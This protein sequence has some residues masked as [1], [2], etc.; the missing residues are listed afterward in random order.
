MNEI[1]EQ[2]AWIVEGVYSSWLAE[3]FKKA[4]IILVIRNSIFLQSYRILH[5]FIL[6]KLNIIQANKKETIR[7]IIDLLKWN[8]GY[9][10]KYPETIEF[11][12]N[13][14]KNIVVIKSN[15]EAQSTIGNIIG[16]SV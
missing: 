12:K 14:N 3:S 1:I 16:K 6:R 13:Y 7:G 15:K 5:R 9:N 4:S 8:Y 2:P 11:I 10:K